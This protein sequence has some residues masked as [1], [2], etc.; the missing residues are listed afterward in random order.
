M[1]P[2]SHRLFRAVWWGTNLLLAASFISFLFACGWEYSVRRYL[3]G[4]SDAI[5]PNT[6]P[7]EQKV[8][9]I[10]N[11]MRLEPSRAFA[12]NPGELAQRDPQM[13]LNYQQLLN[14]CGTATN[15]FLNLARTSDVRVRRLLLLGPDQRA[16]HVVAEV[17]I[18]GRW[19]VV[20]PAY[21]LLLRDAR[22]RL[23]TRKDLQDPAVFR[24]ATG[25]IP[26]YPPEYNYSRFAH[27]RLARLPLDGLGLRK[28]LNSIYPGW[29]E[30]FDWSLIL[31][32]ESFAALSFAAML[33]GVFLLLRVVLAWYA[34]R[35][36]LIP[37]FRLRKQMQR[38]GAAI[39]TT[40]EIK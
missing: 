11:W 1:T 31:E 21:R 10:L 20:D 6:L 19:V 16:R 25:S 33:T 7:A 2:S 5:V 4:F 17:L 3:D 14:V 28:T 8:E 30:L 38:A 26:G 35:R 22:G 37:R 32:R 34:D 18:D 40:P 39:F 15:A 36:L 9:A 27:V 12:A 24:E 23:L 13:T 29:D